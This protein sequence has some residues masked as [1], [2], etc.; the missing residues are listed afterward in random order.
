[1]CSLERSEKSHDFFSS[2][3]RHFQWKQ[4]GKSD[5][6]LDTQRASDTILYVSVFFGSH[7]MKEDKCGNILS[8]NH[9][10]TLNI[11]AVPMICSGNFSSTKNISHTLGPHSSTGFPP[12][13]AQNTLALDGD[14]DKTVTR[15]RMRFERG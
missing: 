5:G 6:T 15:N 7:W 1:M 11:L 3:R 9:S 12:K 14:C 4:I 10:A 2:W 13:K 8:K